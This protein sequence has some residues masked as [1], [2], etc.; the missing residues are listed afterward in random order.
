LARC[1]KIPPA[2]SR[3]TVPVEALLFFSALCFICPS[4][5]FPARAAIRQAAT[6]EYV[7]FYSA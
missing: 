3:L 4:P 6:E 5:G 1:A 7:I 2:A